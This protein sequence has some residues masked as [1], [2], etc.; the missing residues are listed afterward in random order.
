MSVYNSQSSKKRVSLSIAEDSQN[1]QSQSFNGVFGLVYRPVST[2]SGKLQGLNLKKRHKR[3]GYD[4]NGMRQ[5][6]CLVIKPIT[7]DNCCTL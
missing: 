7:V 2:A 5:S 3:I 1:L 6:A 4:L